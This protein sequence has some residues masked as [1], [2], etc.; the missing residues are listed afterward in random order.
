MPLQSQV[1]SS[2]ISAGFV[3]S[4][5]TRK[6]FHL[7][8]DLVMKVPQKY[9]QDYS[10]PLGYLTISEFSLRAGLQFPSPLEL[11]DISVTC[12]ITVGLIVFFRDRG[13]V[14]T[15]VQGLITFISKWLAIRTKINQRVG[16]EKL[17]DL[18]FPFHVGVE[19]ILRMLNIPDV[20][21]LYYEVCYLGKYVKDKYLFKVGLSTQAG[22]SQA[23]I[24]KKS[25]KILECMDLEIEILKEKIATLK[26]I[27]DI[28]EFKKS[29]A[30]RS[31]I[32]E[33]V[34]EARDHIYVVESSAAKTR[35][36]IKML[37]SS[38]ASDA[39]PLNLGDDDIESEF[40][41]VFVSENDDVE[42]V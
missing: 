17:K 22:R 7:S 18:S 12:R 5:L 6:K 8:N 42:I 1:Y 25:F 2:R 28:E 39:Y 10:P 24:L 11:I 33:H 19:D 32:Q 4:T 38:Q 31:I 37:T 35:D 27:E 40:R 36:E 21:T 23:I 13:V 9:D 29:I 20:K 16:L 26:D 14:L 30:F 41:K 15:L 34:Q 3:D